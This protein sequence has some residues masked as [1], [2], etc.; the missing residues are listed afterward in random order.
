M[1]KQKNQRLLYDTECKDCNYKSRCEWVDTQQCCRMITDKL[2]IELRNNRKHRK[3]VAKISISTEYTYSNNKIT[4]TIAREGTFVLQAPYVFGEP[5]L[6]T[7]IRGNGN[8]G[9]F[10]TENYGWKIKK[11]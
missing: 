5:F 10:F 6:R 1:D 8:G 3:I 9:V 7:E 4:K 11:K 2:R